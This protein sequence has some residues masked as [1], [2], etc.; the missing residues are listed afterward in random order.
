[1][2]N[3][4]RDAVVFVTIFVILA[5]VGCDKP[6]AI[7]SDRGNQSSKTTPSAQPDP[8]E[9]AVV[10]L[11]EGKVGDAAKGDSFT[12]TMTLDVHAD[13]TFNLT[14][15]MPDKNDPAKGI[16]NK[17]EGHWSLVGECLILSLERSL[18]GREIPPDQREV[19]FWPS[20]D[21]P[22]QMVS[23]LHLGSVTGTPFRKKVP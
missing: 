23:I 20:S 4:N 9:E 13:K 7:K 11:W 12:A 6:K 14:N 17:A 1:M 10:G 16:T 18:S 21:T 19:K 8:V 3:P 22:G 5:A 15:A 2:H